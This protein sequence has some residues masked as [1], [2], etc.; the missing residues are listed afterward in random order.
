MKKQEEA[1]ET[2]TENTRLR[3]RNKVEVAG[4]CKCEPSY[5]L[6]IEN[7]D[8]YLPTYVTTK[9]LQYNCSKDRPLFLDGDSF[10]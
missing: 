3:A 9:P 10:G 2:L 6:E 7:R 4:A 5:I 8:T 1:K